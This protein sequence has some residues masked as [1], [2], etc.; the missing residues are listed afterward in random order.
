[1]LH[2][3]QQVVRS[4]TANRIMTA[5]ELTPKPLRTRRYVFLNSIELRF[6]ACGVPSGFCPR[7]PLHG[8]E[9]FVVGDLEAN[10]ISSLSVKLRANVLVIQ[11][12]GYVRRVSIAS[13]LRRKLGLIAIA[14][15]V[16]RGPTNRPYL[17]NSVARP[18]LPVCFH[19]SNP[20]VCLRKRDHWDLANNPSEYP[21]KFD[22]EHCTDDLNVLVGS[23][24]PSTDDAV[25]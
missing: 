1:M 14:K 4:D 12:P 16:T 7:S 21:G 23:S 19:L 17:L 8:R 18:E 9:H 25:A 15:N 11:V 22:L 20:P 6:N 24:S 3:A 2:K 10:D 5:P 13:L